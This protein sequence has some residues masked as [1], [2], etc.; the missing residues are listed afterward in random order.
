MTTPPHATSPGAS[1][2]PKLRAFVDGAPFTKFILAVI[3]TNAVVIGL[4]TYHA[5]PVWAIVNQICLAIYIVEIVLKFLARDSVRAF[6][7]DGW[8]LFDLAIIIAAFLPDVG[9]LGTVARILRVFRVLRLVRTIPELRLI[10]SVLVRSVVSMKYI[11]L[12]AVIFFYV[13]AVIGVKVL[14]P[15]Q[16][17][18]RDLHTALFTLFRV[19]TQDNWAELVYT[20]QEHVGWYATA[21]HTGWIILATFILVNLVVGAIIN[22][23]QEVQQIEQRKLKPLDTSDRRLEE[24]I[25]EVQEILRARHGRGS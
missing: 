9:E 8:N 16:P 23:Y 19:L 14:G 7:S 4:E 25:A 24:L 15:H 6:F 3:V 2:M 12:L 18:F 17:E 11:G 13:F 1:R 10:V 20:G 22:N 21:Y 5:S